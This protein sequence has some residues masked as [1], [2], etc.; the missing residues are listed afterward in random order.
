MGDEIMQWQRVAA[1]AYSR[2]RLL[3]AKLC[4]RA[5]VAAA[6]IFAFSFRVEQGWDCVSP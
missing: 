4:N 6:P 2:R 1:N 5:A 3:A